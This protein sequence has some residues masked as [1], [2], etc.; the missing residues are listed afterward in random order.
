V[1]ASDQT[2]GLPKPPPEVEQAVLLGHMEEAVSLCVTHMGV[3][4]GTARAMV[5]R[6]AEELA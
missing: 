5:E 1:E 2:P 4:E 6:L 3:A